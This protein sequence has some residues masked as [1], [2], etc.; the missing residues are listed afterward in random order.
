MKSVYPEKRIS[1]KEVADLIL[2]VIK[3]LRT[4]VRMFSLARICI[5]IYAASVKISQSVCVLREMCRYPVKYYTYSFVMKIIH[6]VHKV[7]R[8]SVS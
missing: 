4:P 2:L 7:L 3:Y 8:T 5:L 1:Y 6:K